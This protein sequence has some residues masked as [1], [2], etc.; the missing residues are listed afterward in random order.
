M[1]MKYPSIDDVAA[2]TDNELADFLGF[3]DRLKAFKHEIGEL[4]EL[5]GEAREEADRMWM[6]RITP[7]IS[8]DSV[9][10]IKEDAIRATKKGKA[11]LDD[12]SPS[13]V[14]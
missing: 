2:M 7:S 6:E 12:T 3:P 4:V 8:S 14:M 13:S 1:M 5:K 9:Q 11:L 10:W